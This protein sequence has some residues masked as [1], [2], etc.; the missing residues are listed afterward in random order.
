MNKIRGYEK[1][2]VGVL[3]FVVQIINAVALPDNLKPYGAVVLALAT[4][5]GVK[6]TR[7]TATPNEAGHADVALITCICLIAI[8]AVAVL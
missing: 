6:Q 5:F 1:F 8:A 2:A 4:A 3:G 7:N